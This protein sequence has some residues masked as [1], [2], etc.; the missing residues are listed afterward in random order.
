MFCVCVCF[1][2]YLLIINRETKYQIL[3]FVAYL[4]SQTHKYTFT[5][6][7]YWLPEELT[8]YACTYLDIPTLVTVGHCKTRYL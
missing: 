8:K 7:S 1:L 4:D 2:F 5:D 6:T 3:I